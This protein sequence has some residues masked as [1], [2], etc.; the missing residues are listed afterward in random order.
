MASTHINTVLCALVP[1]AQNGRLLVK[2]APKS[3]QLY[4]GHAQLA[5][6]HLVRAMQ[7]MQFLAK[8]AKDDLKPTDILKHNFYLK[9]REQ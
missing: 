9:Q 2:L 1:T 4:Y 7:C 3:F 8:S 5:R 6:K